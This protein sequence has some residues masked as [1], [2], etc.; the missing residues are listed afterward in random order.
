MCFLANQAIE[1]ALFYHAGGL[2]PDDNAY[3]I[4]RF[5]TRYNYAFVCFA[6]TIR[7]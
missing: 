6:K 5:I 2:P 7:A 1:Y 4:E 3:E